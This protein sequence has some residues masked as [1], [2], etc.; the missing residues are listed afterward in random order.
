MQ[1]EA[2]FIRPAVPADADGIVRVFLESAE[3]HARLDPERFIV[4]VAEAIVPRYREAQRE[5]SG[6]ITF[7]AELNRQVVGFLD[8]RLGRSTD[9][10]HREL[11]Y[12]FVV[13]IAI[14][15]VCRSQGIGAQLLGAAED[16]GR[17]QG[18]E[19]ASLE[20]L[21]Q[22]TRAAAFYRERMG[23]RVASTTAIKRL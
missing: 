10:M 16:W 11:V 7:V 12:C 15:D 19:F 22:N 2:V 14:T 1:E 9:A 4:P 23:Y 20:Y 21:V 5:D 18:A 13:D 17:V 3:Y 8:A 6:T